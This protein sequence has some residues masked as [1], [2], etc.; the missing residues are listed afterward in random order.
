MSNLPF[1]YPNARQVLAHVITWM[2]RGEADRERRQLRG[3]A[4][5]A[6]LRAARRGEEIATARD[7]VLDLML[8][9]MAFK[10]DEPPV[11]SEERNA[12]WREEIDAAADFWDTVAATLNDRFPE[13]TW[14]EGALP[15]LRTVAVHG[16]YRV[17]LLQAL[18]GSEEDLFD[19]GLLPKELRKLANAAIPPPKGAPYAPITELMAALNA[20]LGHGSSLGQ[21]TV[22]WLVGAAP[23]PTAFRVESV[24]RFVRASIA[25]TTRRSGRA[26]TEGEVDAVVARVMLMVRWRRA[27]GIALD[28]LR[29]ALGG[30]E[31]ADV[32]VGRLVDLGREVASMTRVA[33]CQDDW[34]REDL[35]GLSQAVAHDETLASMRDWAA[36]ADR[37]KVRRTLLT[38]SM[39]R[40]TVGLKRALGRAGAAAHVLVT[41]DAERNGLAA[42]LVCLHGIVD[43]AAALSLRSNAGVADPWHPLNVPQ[44]RG[45]APAEVGALVE[46]VWGRPLTEVQLESAMA[47]MGLLTGSATQ[48][49]SIDPNGL[50][51]DGSVSDMAVR[52]HLALERHDAVAARAA[53]AQARARGGPVELLDRLELDVERD[54]I[55]RRQLERLMAIKRATGSRC[56]ED[57]DAAFGIE[58]ELRTRLAA[59]DAAA[60]ALH[61][62]SEDT[63]ALVLSVD[64]ALEGYVLD[65]LAV[66]I[67]DGAEGDR[68]PRLRL[69]ELDE[70]LVPWLVTHPDDGDA[71]ALTAMIRRV[72]GLRGL[73]EA[74]RRA[75]HLGRPTVRRIRE[76]RTPQGSNRA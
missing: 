47:F 17:G 31:R 48:R 9:L 22:R 14:P 68:D 6:T 35:W 58:A 52:V 69:V 10:G 40:P 41:L 60:M 50:P 34:M 21:N 44:A 37:A 33:A 70:R 23:M 8:A 61:R 74:E 19:P 4:S 75:E 62:R 72:G 55:R 15:F 66:G 26:A 57:E 24:D 56:P 67:G 46:R 2:G 29:R 12:E 3:V 25:I 11:R 73:V 13:L 16:G 59:F 71:W 27:Y 43:A 54:E 39:E 7:A 20:Q 30:G 28:E 32:L 65:W 53:L 42:W 49:A 18:E 63:R 5:G 51:D 45:V 1:R 38:L 64:V 36:R 76:S